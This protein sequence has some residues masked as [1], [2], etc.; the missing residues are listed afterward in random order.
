MANDERHIE[1]IFSWISGNPVPGASPPSEDIIRSW[2]RSSCEYHIDPG[3][4]ERPKILSRNELK[5]YQ[6]PLDQFLWIAKAGLGNLYQQLSALDYVVVLA[7]ANGVNIEF[8]AN[9]SYATELKKAGVYLGSVWSEENEGTNGVG[10]CIKTRK[11]IVIHRSDHF[12]S[13]HSHLTCSVAPVLDPFGKLLA[14]LDASGVSPRSSKESQFL[15]L[16]LVKQTAKLIEKAY[17]LE[18]FRKSYILK[19]FRQKEF[20]QVCPD[21]LIAFDESG[22]ILATNTEAKL[23]LTQTYTE[24]L[25]GKNIT[26]FFKI[27]LDDLLTHTRDQQNL[28]WPIRLSRDDTQSYASLSYPEKQQ[29]FE[30]DQPT[31]AKEVVP[32]HKDLDLETLAGADPVLVHNVHCARRVLNKDIPILLLGET[33]TGKEV[34]ARAIHNSSN[35]SKNAFVALNCA[36]IPESL[37]ESELFGYEEGAFTGAKKKGMQG[38]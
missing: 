2:T 28:V 21:E 1:N 15:V 29:I 13:S 14:V 3:T 18:E 30:A 24:T 6:E 7:D 32:I 10:V 12:K 22:S 11:P 25:I 26:N 16:Q 38:K 4:R 33:G 36:S 5:T 23:H 27:S 9:K 8:K 19:L 20:A 17:F 37:I 34:F 31:E 35:R